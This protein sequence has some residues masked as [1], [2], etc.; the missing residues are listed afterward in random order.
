M[1]YTPAPWNYAGLG[2]RHS[3]RIRRRS[4]VDDCAPNY[5][6]SG[7]GHFLND[8]LNK[9]TIHVLELAPLLDENPALERLGSQ[10]RPSSEYDSRKHT[11]RTCTAR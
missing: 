3:G 9:A 2:V 10:C 1:L 7:S 11:N 8:L 5:P 6:L 4:F